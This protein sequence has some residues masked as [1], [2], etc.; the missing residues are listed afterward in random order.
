MGVPVVQP[1]RGAMPELVEQTG[2][3]LLFEAENV[4]SLTAT[5]ARVLTD[6]TAARQ[7]GQDGMQ[8]V[9]ERFSAAKA[10]E[11]LERIYRSLDRATP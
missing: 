1:D 3:G 8:A 2:G 6:R 9:R 4:E 5:L 11:E 7:L 10:A